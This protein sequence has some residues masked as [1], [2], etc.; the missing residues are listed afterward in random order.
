MPYETLEEVQDVEE[1]ARVAGMPASHVLHFGHDASYKSLY[2][3]LRNPDNY[4]AVWAELTRRLDD[5][6]TSS[7]TT[8]YG[9]LDHRSRVYSAG[10]Y[11]AWYTYCLPLILQHM[12]QHNVLSSSQIRDKHSAVFSRPY[13]L[14]ALQR[15]RRSSQVV[16]KPDQYAH[17]SSCPN[18]STPVDTANMF[19][20]ILVEQDCFRQASCVRRDWIALDTY[21]KSQSGVVVLMRKY[22]RDLRARFRGVCTDTKDKRVICVQG[23]RASGKTGLVVQTLEQEGYDVLVLN[24]ATVMLSSYQADTG[25]TTDD[26]V[27]RQCFSLTDK[28][29]A[30]LYDYVIGRTGHDVHTMQHARFALVFEDWG[31]LGARAS[32]ASTPTADT[33]SSRTTTTTTTSIVK[34]FKTLL[35]KGGVVPENRNGSS[36]S[37]AAAAQIPL[38]VIMNEPIEASERTIWNASMQVHTTNCKVDEARGMLHALRRK[39]IQE[40]AS[41]VSSSSTSTTSTSMLQIDRTSN[42]LDVVM[43]ACMSGGGNSGHSGRAAR[44]HDT[45]NTNGKAFPLQKALVLFDWV[46]LGHRADTSHMF[47]SMYA[48][49][50]L[51]RQHVSRLSMDEDHGIVRRTLAVLASSSSTDLMPSTTMK[52][53]QQ[54]DAVK[55]IAELQRQ[56]A[57]KSTKNQEQHDRLSQPASGALLCGNH[58]HT[59]SNERNL[60]QQFA[61]DGSGVLLT[62][63]HNYLKTFGSGARMP[64]F[65]DVDADKDAERMCLLSSWLSWWDLSFTSNWQDDSD[66][67]TA[68]A[69]CGVR[70]ATSACRFNPSKLSIEYRGVFAQLGHKATKQAALQTVLV[71]SIVAAVESDNAE[72]LARGGRNWRKS[73]ETLTCRILAHAA[74]AASET[75]EMSPSALEAVAR[76]NALRPANARE[77]SC[78]LRYWGIALGCAPQV[79][80]LAY[81]PYSVVG[82]NSRM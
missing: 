31:M 80:D 75:V 81:T 59:T 68:V 65:V 55:Y 41:Y 34:T 19:E 64:G 46:T 58:Q 16:V 77:T 69:L 78:A 50:E 32:S 63:A 73:N 62:C 2:L 56:L 72:Q 39:R 24:A 48:N 5:A 79:M 35:E 22:V 4:H 53:E 28:T 66:T 61:T 25:N 36:V 82:D 12:V 17:M 3:A 60:L 49:R 30:A 40:L 52:K 57:G 27:L 43:E 1:L 76:M 74:M 51:L 45:T 18:L 44:K 9:D 33:Q 26:V 8:R 13:A 20:R 42:L 14:F 11:S 23:P 47:N 67:S 29:L 21:P 71:E 10:R 38:V 15:K 54:C 7:N 6:R 70:S 37:V